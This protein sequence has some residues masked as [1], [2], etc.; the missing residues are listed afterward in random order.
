MN[1]LFN[2]QGKWVTLEVYQKLLNPEEVKQ[3]VKET[4]VVEKP[5]ET[6]EVEDVKPV[7]KTKKLTKK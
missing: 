6:P 2:H 5:V 7:K 3:E 4:K 1:Q